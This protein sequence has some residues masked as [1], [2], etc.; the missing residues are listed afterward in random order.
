[1]PSGKYF[2]Q[3]HNIS[4]CQ[5]DLGET[6]LGIH[7][8]HQMHTTDKRA[9]C[10]QMDGVIFFSSAPLEALVSGACRWDHNSLVGRGVHLTG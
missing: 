3:S 5:T 8:Y 4:K 7:K 6:D 1:M 10:T 9:P 2:G